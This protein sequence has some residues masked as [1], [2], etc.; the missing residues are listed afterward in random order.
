MEAF[1]KRING[2]TLGYSEVCAWMK[3]A[4]KV[5]DV[6]IFRSGK[7]FMAQIFMDNKPVSAPVLLG[8]AGVYNHDGHLCYFRNGEHIVEKELV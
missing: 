5:A 4:G 6:G 1:I 7:T 3:V 2:L 8:E